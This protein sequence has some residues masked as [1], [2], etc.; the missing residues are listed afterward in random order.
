MNNSP[1]S[2]QCPL[3]GAETSRSARSGEIDSRTIQR[4]PLKFNTPRG[5][6]SHLGC[7]L[8]TAF[9]EGSC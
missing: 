1:V 5:Y 6:S 8:D 4:N 9:Y 2:K 7:G 3:G